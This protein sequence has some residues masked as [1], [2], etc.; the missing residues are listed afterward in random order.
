MTR[1][2]LRPE[3]KT[4]LAPILARYSEELHADHPEPSAAERRL[5]EVASLARGGAC[6]VLDAIKNRD[7]KA[8]DAP[9]MAL[10]STLTRVLGLERA[11]LSDLGLDKRA[12]KGDDVLALLSGPVV[13]DAEVVV[14]APVPAA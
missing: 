8:G 10:L 14:P 2:A 5:I 9:L 7:P 6:L 4:W 13:D 1:R 11:V 3:D 12:R